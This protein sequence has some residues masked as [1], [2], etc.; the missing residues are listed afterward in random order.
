LGFAAGESI[1]DGISTLSTE[2]AATFDLFEA[3]RRLR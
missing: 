1:L 2:D 3:H